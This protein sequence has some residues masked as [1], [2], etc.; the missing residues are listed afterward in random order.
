MP[1]DFKDLKGKIGKLLSDEKLT[2]VITALE[3]DYFIQCL[4]LTYLRG[5]ENDL[6][7]N[8]RD[9][10]VNNPWTYVKNQLTQF[11]VRIPSDGT[12]RAR[13][14]EL[15]DLGLVKSEN[16]DPLKKTYATTERGNKVSELLIG[17]LSQLYQ[18]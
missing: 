17:F 18:T 8:E 11:G 12:Y 9:P 13:M 14:R 10:Y 5:K 15:E 6:P 7:K 4:L 2:P 3:K 1:N 16:I